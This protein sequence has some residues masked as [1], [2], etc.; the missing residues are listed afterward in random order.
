MTHNEDIP[1]DFVEFVCRERQIGRETAEDL[2]RAFVRDFY[3]SVT[4]SPE[5]AAPSLPARR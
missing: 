5:V 4:A 2:L 3:R 1:F